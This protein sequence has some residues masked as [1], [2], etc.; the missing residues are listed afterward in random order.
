MPSPEL[1][2]AIFSEESRRDRAEVH[3]GR[4]CHEAFTIAEFEI[5]TVPFDE[6]LALAVDGKEPS[7]V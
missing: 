5:V 3:I 7:R 1:V 4:P 2:L 6:T